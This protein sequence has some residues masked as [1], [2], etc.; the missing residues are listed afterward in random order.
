MTYTEKHL[1][2][3]ADILQMLDVA[4]IEKVV[5]SLAEVKASGGRL[6]FLGVGEIE[7]AHV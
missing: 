5:E 2:E 7:R 1:R 4:A 3:A 6:F